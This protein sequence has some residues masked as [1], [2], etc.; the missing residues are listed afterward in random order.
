MG[1]FSDLNW[2]ISSSREDPSTYKTLGRAVNR[3]EKLE[4]EYQ[5]DE[6]G[7]YLWVSSNYNV[8]P[9]DKYALM[10]KRLPG[11]M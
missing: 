6:L 3:L 11:S 5:N 9:I 10:E 4:S 7:L 8:S 2:F 1:I